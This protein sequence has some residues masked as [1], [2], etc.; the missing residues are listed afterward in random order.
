MSLNSKRL[1]GASVVTRSGMR[2]GKLASFE[3]D[4]DTGKLTSILVRPTGNVTALLS[5][6]LI[7]AWS[8]IISMS[9]KKIVVSDTVTAVESARLAVASM[10]SASASLKE[11]TQDL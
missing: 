7:I 4:A 9:E 3:I 6:D 10:P 2:V 1:E 5:G 8:Q 11:R